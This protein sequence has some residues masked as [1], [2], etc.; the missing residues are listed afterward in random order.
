MGMN[1]FHDAS[2]GSPSLQPENRSRA[3]ET[4][5]GPCGIATAWDHCGLTWGKRQVPCMHADPVSSIGVPA[6]LSV[7]VGISGSTRGRKSTVRSS[8]R[9]TV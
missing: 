8:G 6:K 7:Y 5:F 4:L 1:N 2:P 3:K 9:T